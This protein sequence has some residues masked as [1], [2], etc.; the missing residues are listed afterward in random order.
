MKKNFGN[1]H[2]SVLFFEKVLSKSLP[3][4]NFATA[5]ELTAKILKYFD[6]LQIT[7]P[8]VTLSFA[9]DSLRV[10][11]AGLLRFHIQA[12][13][14]RVIIWIPHAYS[15]E[16]SKEIQTLQNLFPTI[17]PTVSWEI[18]EEGLNFLKNYIANHWIMSFDT[19]DSQYN[20]KKHSRYIS[21]EVRQAVLTDFLQNGK[22]CAG[23]HGLTKRHKVSDDTRLEFD[24]ILPHAHGG[25]NGFWNIQILC[26][27]CNR[28]KRAS[29]C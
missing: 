3:R 5:F 9:T 25:S 29:A 1:I 16:L 20:Q 10:Y 13:T 27:E 23:V 11:Y 28:L 2:Y 7:N 24:H 15:Q 17:L 12:R 6:E 8:L 18:T 19:I 22:W 26:E 4:E 21:G 14:G